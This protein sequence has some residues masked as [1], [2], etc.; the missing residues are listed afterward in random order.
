[1]NRSDYRQVLI[2][3][4]EAP[5]A[6]KEVVAGTIKTT[7]LCCGEGE[8]VVLL[9]GAGA[10]AVTWSKSIALLSQYFH[11]IAPDIV[12]YGESD[13]P[14]AP[15]DRHYFASWLKQFLSALHIDKAH[16]VGLSQGGAIALQFVLE[17]P[18]MV[19]KLVLVNAG[20]LGAK[21][22]LLPFLGMLWLNS[23]PSSLAYRFY[24]RFLLSDRGKRDKAHGGYSVA[25]LKSE[26]GKNAFF[27][28]KGAA[29]SAI[30]ESQLRDIHHETLIMWGE[31]DKLFPAPCGEKAAQIMPNAKWCPIAG[32]GHLPLMEQTKVFNNAL[33]EFLNGQH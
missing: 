15:Y 10:G 3:T 12:G 6:Q 33:L 17:Y 16:I 8:P 13:K 32:A 26:G 27:Q 14:D 28:G 1:M 9:H 25:V 29:V 18:D 30:P 20:G 2:D 23:M 4:I 7:Y 11:V 31:E 24:S 21:P 19:D 22:S 5:V